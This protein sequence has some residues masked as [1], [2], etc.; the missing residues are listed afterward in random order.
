MPS[1]QFGS[2][3]MIMKWMMFPAAVV[4]CGAVTSVGHAQS[5]GRPQQGLTMAQRVCAE[6]HA[7]QKD[8]LRSPNADA[9]PFARLATT[10][11]MTTIALTAALRTSHRTMP[12]IVLQ[13]DEAADV[14]AYILSLKNGD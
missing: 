14:I 2:L 10:P 5:A 6:C 9:P 11:G 12:N 4:I 3:W 8:D 13:A 1:G 7:V